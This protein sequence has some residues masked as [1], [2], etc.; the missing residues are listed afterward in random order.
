MD[1]DVIIVGAGPTGLLLAGDLA[2]AGVHCTLLERHKEPSGLTRA[3]AVHART[4]EQLDM[5]GLA[6]EL[7]ATGRVVSG[8]RLFSGIDVDLH[9]LRTRF[10]FA[11]VT[12]Q[13]NT[14][15]LLETRARDEGVVVTRGATVTGVAQSDVSA[16]VTFEQDGER[17]HLQAAYVVGADGAHSQVRA[18]LGLEFGGHS[19]VRSVMLAD[20]RLTDQPDDVL[21]VDATREG[22]AF[23]A[24][25]GDG[26][27]R[28][29]AWDR[30][31]QQPESQPTSLEEVRDITRRVLRSDY[32]MH[33][34]RWLSRFHSDERQVDRY[35][36]GRVMLAG[37]AA[38]V[39]SPA[40]GQGMN[41]GLQDAANLS[42]KLASATHVSAGAERLL[43]TYH[44]ERHPVGSTVLRSSSAL[45]HAAM[46]RSS[47]ARAFRHLLGHSV[48]RLPPVMDRVAELISGLSV[49]YPSDFPGGGRRAPDSLLLQT[50]GTTTRLYDALRERK[51]VWIRPARSTAAP[52]DHPGVV[53][54]E[55]TQAAAHA[56]VRPD[57]YLA[58]ARD[59]S[60]SAGDRP[61]HEVAAALRHWLP[62]V[63]H[64]R[65]ASDGLRPTNPH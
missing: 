32:G 4:L 53:N 35:R 29:I 37:D 26:W 56:L 64:E 36:L 25:F 33:D 7:L 34:A 10:P 14:E 63:Q 61:E 30:F 18:A 59:A 23:I 58:Y 43:D 45:L 6:D 20:V 28:I 47:P 39:H 16:T 19:A 52:V 31:N 3:F 62:E 24:P 9:R 44:D 2:A 41:T 50:D 1:T 60:T 5:R 46:L 38:H 12:P 27:Y 21:T 54:L 40:G 49:H 65:T 17:S 42:W 57:G 8:L 13:T 11:L 15:R 51:L 22:F 55:S 48:L